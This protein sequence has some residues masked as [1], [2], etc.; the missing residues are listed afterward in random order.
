M[1]MAHG[2]RR[3]SK[4]WAFAFPVWLVGELSLMWAWRYFVPAYGF[5]LANPDEKMIA[6]L[7][8]SGMFAWSLALIWIGVG[9]VG[10]MRTSQHRD[11][12]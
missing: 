9:T 6:I 10:A 12:S 3:P 7:L 8:A 5:D 11:L 1:C 4:F 2:P